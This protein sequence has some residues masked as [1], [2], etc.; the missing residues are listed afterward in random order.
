MKPSLTLADATKLCVT[1]E[2]QEGSYS[3]RC[4][5][6][7][8]TSCLTTTEKGL[9]WFFCLVLHYWENEELILQKQVQNLN[10]ARSGMI[11]KASNDLWIGL[12]VLFSNF[13]LGAWGEK[14]QPD[15]HKYHLD[16]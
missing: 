4:A 12:P 11:Y 9:P 10:L 1:Q 5:E 6:L 8:D 3:N 15:R 16:F 13:I 7:G 14:N 2:R